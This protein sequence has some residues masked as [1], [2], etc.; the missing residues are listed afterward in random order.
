MKNCEV[1]LALVP[2]WDGNIG[3]FW[4]HLFPKTPNLRAVHRRIPSE[5]NPETEWVT[6]AHWA[7]EEKPTAKRI[8][9]TEINSFQKTHPQHSNTQ[10]GDNLKLPACEAWSGWTQPIAP[11][12]FSL[13]PEGWPPKHLALKASEACVS[14]T[15]KTIANR[16]V[17]LNSSCHGCPPEFTAETEDRNTCFPSF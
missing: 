7:N 8:R 15:L 14:G 1:G 5:R 17:I 9:K 11:Q 4:T 16:E 12:H 13:W 10:S 6:P 3:V 2:V